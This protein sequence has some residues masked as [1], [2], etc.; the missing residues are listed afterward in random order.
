MSVT[1]T[2][3]HGYN[4]ANEYCPQCDNRNRIVALEQE[5]ATL[6]AEV[7]EQKELLDECEKVIQHPS[8]RGY[9]QLLAK[10]KNRKEGT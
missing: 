1:G 2:C 10:L 3:I 9:V 4:R 8:G 6:R 7:A 5:L